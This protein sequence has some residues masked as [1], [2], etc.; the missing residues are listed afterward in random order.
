MVS[1]TISSHELQPPDIG[2]ISYTGDNIEVYGYVC[3]NV[4]S[5]GINYRLPLYIANTN[6]HPLLGREWLYTLPFDWNKVIRSESTVA[7]YV[8]ATALNTLK[9]KYPRD[10]NANTTGKITGK[11]ARFYLK[12]NVKPHGIQT[13]AN[14]TQ[15]S[16]D[17]SKFT[18]HRKS[19]TN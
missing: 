7:S 3:V 10:S 2:L 17:E 18:T 5:M 8:Q 9:S 14:T 12:P 16:V 4:T 13:F 6:R 19:I 15:K 11:Q 1:P